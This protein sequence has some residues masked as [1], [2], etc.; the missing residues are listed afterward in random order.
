MPLNLLEVGSDDGDCFG[1]KITIFKVAPY[2]KE[3]SISRELIFQKKE[4]SNQRRIIKPSDLPSYKGVL[5][6]C[7]SIGIKYEDRDRIEFSINGYVRELR[8]PIKIPFSEIDSIEIINDE[9]ENKNKALLKVIVFPK[10]SVDKLLNEKNTYKKLKE[11]YSEE[12]LI[13]INIYDFSDGHLQL[14]CNEDNYSQYTLIDRFVNLPKGKKIPLSY[15]IRSDTPI[16][17]AIDAII[18]DE[19]YPYQETECI[20]NVS[21]K[22]MPRG[23]V[24]NIIK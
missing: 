1:E 12:I 10:I 21:I 24:Y 7:H 13:I 3:E 6:R 9:N 2:S 20:N 16:W 4:N 22:P 17:W 11:K 14:V 23:G 18:N 5:R 8:R 15:E 19:T